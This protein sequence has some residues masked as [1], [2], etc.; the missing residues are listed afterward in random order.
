MAVFHPPTYCPFC[1]EEIERRFRSQDEPWS[2][3]IGDDSYIDW[4]G[5]KCKSKKIR[6][7]FKKLLKKV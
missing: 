1:G 4:G 5:H 2:T 7:F 6:K 3:F